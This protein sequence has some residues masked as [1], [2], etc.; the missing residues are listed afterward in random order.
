[1]T[2]FQSRNRELFSRWKSTGTALSL[3]PDRRELVFSAV[4]AQ[5]AAD[6]KAPFALGQ[7]LNDAPYRYTRD[8]LW[9]SLNSLHDRLAA[10]HPAIA[11]G[12]EDAFKHPTIAT[13][14]DFVNSQ[15]TKSVSELITGVMDASRW[16]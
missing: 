9:A 3:A 8:E 2:K 7:K 15:L 4:Q 12:T 16:A 6:G 13:F 11:F 1:M 14:S 10:T 5:L